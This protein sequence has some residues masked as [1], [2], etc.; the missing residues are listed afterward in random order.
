M[1]SE[2]FYTSPYGLTKVLTRTLMLITQLYTNS[3]NIFLRGLS[4]QRPL[5][6]RTAIA[7]R[8]APVYAP[9]LRTG[10]T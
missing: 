10:P 1:L 5:G 3:Q 9:G 8:C 4:S 2:H 6:F 7:Y